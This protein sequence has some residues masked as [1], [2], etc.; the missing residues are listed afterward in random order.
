MENAKRDQNHVTTIMGVD[1]STGNLPTKI[2][3]DE[4]THRLL[5]SAVITSLPALSTTQAKYRTKID[6]ASTTV[7]Y[8]GK[9]ELTGSAIS[10]A[11]AVWQIMKIDETTNPTEISFADGNTNFDNVWDS[12]SSLTYA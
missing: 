1:L 12:R 3:V 11:S 7:T 6:E 9:A 8:V 5:V 2:Y 10:G 4:V